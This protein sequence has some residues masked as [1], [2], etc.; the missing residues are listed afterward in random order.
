M[1]CYNDRIVCASKNYTS[2]SFAFIPNVSKCFIRDNNL[3]QIHFSSVCT[4]LVSRDHLAHTYASNLDYEQ[5]LLFCEVSRVSQKLKI[6]EKKLMSARR[7]E[8]LEWGTRKEATDSNGSDY[9]LLIS[10]RVWL[11]RCTHTA[12]NMTGY[13]PEI[14]Q[15]VFQRSRLIMADDL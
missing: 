10:S 14:C 9:R 7:G 11:L 1:W 2:R 5:S 15:Q 3:R 13:Q 4:L 12:Q 6:S 8:L